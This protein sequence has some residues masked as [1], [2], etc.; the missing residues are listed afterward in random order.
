[1]EAKTDLPPVP[2]SATLAE[3]PIDIPWKTNLRRLFRQRSAVIGMIILGFVVTVAILAPVLTVYDPTDSLIGQPGHE[4]I[5]RRA[6]PCIHLLGCPED[7]PQHLMGLDGNSRDVFSR[8]LYGARVSLRVGLIVVGI[9]VTIG[10]FLGSVAGYVGGWTDNII[11]RLMDLILAFPSLLLAIAITFVL[12]S[13]LF[14]AMLAIS[15]VSIPGYARVV[16]STVLAARNLDYVEAAHSLGASHWRILFRQIL[17]NAITPLIVQATLGIGVAI[18]DAAALSFLGLGAQEP[19]PEWG[20]MLGRERNQIF[21]APHLVLFPG[22]AIAITVL[23]F[24]LLGDGLR[25]VLDPRLSRSE[26]SK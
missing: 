4:N 19:T 3:K 26:Q 2:R 11:M 23:A 5:Q 7:Q 25:D 13:G 18:I 22:F 12:G 24:N 17:P 20:T 16:R 1:M 8:I 14:N 6:K 9:S 21:S 15:I 10:T